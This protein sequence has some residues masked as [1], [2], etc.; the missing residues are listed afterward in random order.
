[1]LPQ[2]SN[3][4]VYVYYNTTSTFLYAHYNEYKNQWQIACSA[5][6]SINVIDSLYKAPLYTSTQRSKAC[7]LVITI[8]IN[9]KLFPERKVGSQVQTLY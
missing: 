5:Y 3:I 7:N 2:L 6:S 9:Y 4:R 8:S 1:M